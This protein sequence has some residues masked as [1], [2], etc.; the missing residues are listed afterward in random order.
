[1]P[2]VT[3]KNTSTSQ[4][5][6]EITTTDINEINAVE[7]DLFLGIRYFRATLSSNNYYLAS[8]KTT[9]LRSVESYFFSSI[10]SVVLRLFFLVQ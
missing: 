8:L 9:C 7:R 4:T 10:R 3:D 1:M 5:T 6:R 2:A